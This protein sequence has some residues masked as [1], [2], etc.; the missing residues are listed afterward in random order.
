MRR[1]SSIVPVLVTTLMAVGPALA[2]N[3]V[4]PQINPGVIQNQNRQ[5]ENE[6][7]EQTEQTLVGPPVASTN[8]PKT[9]VG[10]PGGTRFLLNSVV[11]T[12]SAFIKKDE[13][14]AIV[15]PFLARKVD[16]AD[17]QRIVKAVNDIYAERGI[18]TASAVLPPQDLKAGVLRISLVEGKLDKVRV[19]GNTRLRSD[20]VRDHVATQPGDV[21]DVPLLIREV[22]AFNK[23]GVAQI[24]ASLQPGVSFGLTTIDLAV[25]EPP[26]VTVN[27]FSDNQGV[28]SVNR[29]EGGFLIQGYSPL[30]IDD[31]LTL[32]GVGSQGDLNGNIA[33]SIPF[34]TS[35]GRVGLSYNE[36]QIYVVKGPFAPLGIK[37]R[38]DI[39]SVNVVQPIFVNADFFLL[40]NG[41]FAQ[42]NSSSREMAIPLTE[43]RTNRETVGLSVGF[44][45]GPFAASVTPSFSPAQTSFELTSTKQHFSLINGVYA[46]S[47]RL[48]ADFVAQVGGA[49][50]VAS[51][52][53]V[54]G[55]Q[56]FQI[57][58][59][60]TVRG[61]MT[62]LFA[63]ATGYY[64]NFELHHPLAA[65]LPGLDVFA[66]YDRGSVYSVTPA[67][68]T[69]NSVG[70][71]LTYDFKQRVLAELSFGVPLDHPAADQASLQV[72]FRLTAK[73]N[74]ND[75]VSLQ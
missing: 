44:Q 9:F 69:L 34:D 1:V 56:L 7:R 57:G 12:E 50:Q 25:I 33:Y 10:P 26:A 49:F 35:G 43:N 72:Y 36:G 48:P 28:E 40:G 21:V 30:G 20:F 75:L 54:A 11:F 22:A 24:Q 8:V 3:V 15:A 18:V 62:P 71:G 61:Y 47:V 37:G 23:T 42:Y 17:V 63:G 31:R 39:A 51:A 13:L 27:L 66:F 14:D 59:S 6:V 19:V 4:N 65:V 60:T 64:S 58:G 53:L 46:A 55:D 67:V 38:S 73:F 32:Y 41:S 5:N 2:Q 68:E 74:S 29:Y 52:Q 16:I 70:A 45:H